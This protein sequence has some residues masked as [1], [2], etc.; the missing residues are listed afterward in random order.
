M[1]AIDD[2]RD[3][4]V[5]GAAGAELAEL[6]LPA[7]YRGAVTR[8]ADAERLRDAPTDGRDP[9]DTLHVDDVPLPE[10]APDEC[11]VAVMA[12]SINYNTIWSSTFLPVPTFAFLDRYAAR[13]GAAARHALDVHVLG[14]DAAGVVLRAGSAVRRWSPGDRVVVH[15]TVVDGQ[16]PAT[17]EDG[18]LAP[19][20]LAWGYETNFGGLAELAVVKAT[21]LLPKAPH[22]TWEEAAVVTACNATSYRM[23]IS[24]NGAALRLGESV[25]V[26]GATG[27]IGI[28]AVQLAQ[29]TG[30]QVVG[31]VSRPERA[32][33][34]AELGAPLTIDRSAGGYRFWAD[35]HT[36]DPLEWRRFA[37]DVKALLGEEP[38]VVFEHPGR[39]TMGASVFT[40]AR[41]GTVVT[42][43]ATTGYDL[44]YDNR[45]LW[46]KLKRIVSSHSANYAECDRSNRLV[47]RGVITPA[48]SATYSLD[49]VADATA[50]VQHNA[51]DGKIAV[52]GLAPGT[53]LGVDDPARR[54][55]IGERRVTSF[56]HALGAVTGVAHPLDRTDAVP[57]PSPGV[58][59]P[60]RSP[61]S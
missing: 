33:L 48:L 9:R 28:Y 17:H 56:A 47:H 32:A 39:E 40:C 43:A 7:T 4:I 6:D 8:R 50:T 23:L 53:G 42:C 21:Q 22:L 45:H 24:D 11:L 18:M 57:A 54:E 10:L 36:Q 14:S 15:P 12:S 2:I 30:A 25:L 52:L 13:G 26:W 5:G 1:G 20:Q 16:D 19:A 41:G 34:L 55:A 37:G 38:R 3:A 59:P 44:Q 46:M 29:A 61:I 49:G 51:H 27:G 35:E 31:V 58:T 60:D